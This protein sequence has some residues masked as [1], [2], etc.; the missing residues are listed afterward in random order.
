ME[1]DL[2]WLLLAL[3]GFFLLG[4]VASRLDLR[5]LKREDSAS[6]QAYFKGLNLLLNEQQDKAIDAFIEAVQQDPNT[7]D[8]HFA[9]G[10]L[11]RRRGE[12]ERA[13]RVHE[14]LLAR[15]DLRRDDRERAQHALAQD[16]LKAG[17]FDR[18]ET[19]FKALEG[20]AFST[21]S[22]LALLTLH[23]RSRNWHPA[24][25]VARQLEAA[26]TGSF[27][28]RMAH[29][30]C[31][32][33]H[34]AD[35]RGRHDEAEQALVRAREAAPQAARPLVMQGH[36]LVRQGQHAA[37]LKVWDE[38]MALQPQAFSLVAQDYATSAQASDG[39]AEALARLEALYK[40]APSVDLLSAL[41]RLQD[42]PSLRRQRLITHLSNQPSLSAAQG[43][44][45]ESLSTGV[46]LT[47]P[48]IERLQD[49]LA[50][51]AKPLQR[52]RC[53]ACGFES[54][55]Y[56]W[57]CPGCHGWDT[58]PPRRLEDQ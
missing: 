8:L 44:I 50:T 52:Y 14:H 17:L 7:S 38:L 11:F 15:G 42:E 18:A 22:R 16:F 40:Q 20:T 5:Q 23:E 45:R 3:P 55:H 51:A 49:A 30:W 25:E 47:V 1:F 26:G 39:V 46:P 33:A 58:Y 29:H 27:A 56:F 36:R 10:N 54:Q 24:I 53:A 57:Q 48:E 37:A 6:P 43:V 31:E 35:A 28:Q 32:V 12:Y 21:D 19:A 2:Q 34:E 41:N 13:I 9:L 4:W